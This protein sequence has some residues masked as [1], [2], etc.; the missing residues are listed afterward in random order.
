MTTSNPH[1]GGEKSEK[2]SAKPPLEGEKRAKAVALLKFA[3]E[4]MNEAEEELCL[5]INEESRYERAL[6]SMLNF[7][8]QHGSKAEDKRKKLAK[9]FLLSLVKEDKTASA[10]VSE[11]TSSW[12]K[13]IGTWVWNKMILVLFILVLI[14]GLMRGCSVFFSNRGDLKQATPSTGTNG[15]VDGN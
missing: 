7:E 9:A 5:K 6:R 3:Q 12:A 2:T 13:R 11:P 14:L 4:G 10:A 8:E 15:N 1:D